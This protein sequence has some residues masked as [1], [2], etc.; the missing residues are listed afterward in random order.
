MSK[1]SAAAAR[2]REAVEPEHIAHDVLD[3][4]QEAHLQADDQEVT[5]IEVGLPGL[6]GIT[7][8]QQLDD[9][10]LA[11]LRRRPQRERHVIERPRDGEV[12]LGLRQAR[13]RHE[14]DARQERID[15]VEVGRA[16]ADVELRL[17]VVDRA[18]ALDGHRF[19]TF[20]WRVV[21]PKWTLPVRYIS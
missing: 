5:G 2:D 19:S 21:P 10:R 13:V 14:R 7:Q 12:D 11:H 3:L 4:R 15:L 8:R 20:G 9:L 18:A 17:E 16:L 6:V 1:S